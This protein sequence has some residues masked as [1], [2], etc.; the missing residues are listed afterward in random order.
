YTSSEEVRDEVARMSS[1]SPDL[2]GSWHCPT[3]LKISSDEVHTVSDVPL[4][5]VDATVR[6]APALQDTVDAKN[7]QSVAINSECAKKHGLSDSAQ[8]RL[9]VSGT[10]ISLPL[11]I[12]E[13]VADD[14]IYV[15]AAVSATVMFDFSQEAVH[16]QR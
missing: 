7:S 2:T 15:P 9:S 12:N 10:D 14:C 6:R 4:Y 8:I 1:A 11:Q 5:A 13:R 16:I 3:E